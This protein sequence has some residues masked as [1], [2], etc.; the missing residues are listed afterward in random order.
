MK[1]TT[2]VLFAAML[3]TLLAPGFVRAQDLVVVGGIL[4]SADC[5]ANVLALKTADGSP[6]VFVTAPATGIYVNSAPAALCA[7]GQYAG[8]DATVWSTT[9]GDRSLATRVDVSFPIASPGPQGPGYGYG[10]FGYGPFQYG[11]YFDPY[12]N[13][14][15]NYNPYHY[16]AYPYPY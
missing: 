1:S 9:A 11:P 4:Q 12:Y 8:R 7:L 2:A 6:R 5:Q 15:L 13:P 14:Y 10:L 3:V 16:G